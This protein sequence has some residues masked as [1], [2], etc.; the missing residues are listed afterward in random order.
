M[1]FYQIFILISL[2]NSLKGHN[3]HHYEKLA[4][5]RRFLKKGIK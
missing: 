3:H 4:N 1:K 5:K 2:L